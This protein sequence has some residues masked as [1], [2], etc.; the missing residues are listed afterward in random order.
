LPIERSALGYFN[1]EAVAYDVE[2]HVLYMT[3]D[4]NDGRLYRFIPN[5]LTS[6]G[7]ADLQ[8]G[9]LEGAQVQQLGAIDG[10]SWHPVPDPLGLDIPIR[11]QVTS[12]T[13]FIRGEGICYSK[14]VI[15]FTTTGDDR[16]WFYDIAS[17]AISILYDGEDAQAHSILTG[18]DNITS[19]SFGDLLVAEDGGDLQI[20]VISSQGQV[21]PIVQL[22]GHNLS[23]ITGPAFSPDQSRLYFS[24]QNGV[25]G[26]GGDGIT[27]EIKFP[28]I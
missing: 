14:G 27:F 1:H 17:H 3:E 15:F 20:V 26:H 13:P 18:P 28:E 8:S 6:S 4:R 11:H 10:V 7:F 12:S 25:T 23:E 24:S 22:E 19:N 2:S 21:F 9:T 5:F 16:V